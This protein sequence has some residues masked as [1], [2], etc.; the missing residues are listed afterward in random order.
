MHIYYFI[1]KGYN[2][3][4]VDSILQPQTGIVEMQQM[5]LKRNGETTW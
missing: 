2:S 5:L 1:R 4:Q 3:E